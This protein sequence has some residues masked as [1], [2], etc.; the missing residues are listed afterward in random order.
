MIPPAI[1]PQ[2]VEIPPKTAPIKSVIES[3]ELNES[4]LRYAVGIE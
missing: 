1:A 3:A 2:N 4:G